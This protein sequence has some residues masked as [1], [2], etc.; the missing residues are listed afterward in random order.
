MAT[1]ENQDAIN[2]LA[3]AL[4]WYAERDPR[5]AEELAE[6]EPYKASVGTAVQASP[7][8]VVQNGDARRD[9]FMAAGNMTVDQ[10]KAKSSPDG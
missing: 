3:R 9:L 2:E 1:P 4:C 8:T 5:F 7:G 10:S 6:W